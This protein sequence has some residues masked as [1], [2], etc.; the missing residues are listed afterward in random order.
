MK[1]DWYFRIAFALL[2]LIYILIRVPHDKVYKSNPGKLKI[3]QRSERLLIIFMFI[4]FLLLP[5]LWVSTPVF[6][7]FK[8]L[9]PDWIRISGVILA[10]I[11]LL[12][13]VRIHAA[14]GANWSPTLEIRQRHEF[15]CTGPYNRIRHPMYL[16][17][18]MW[19]C[20]QFMI[21]SNCIAGISG[22]MAWLI[23]YFVRVPKEEQMMISV[24]GERY[25]QY[26]RK[27]GRIFPKFFSSSSDPK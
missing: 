14:L 16:Q 21:L 18:L 13:F 27:T 10:A 24:F 22:L 4:G 20:A 7:D 11:S 8:L 12:Y 17:M 15:V 19:T 26:M 2:W 1:H 23:L 3:S 6:N 5:L 25:V 9:F